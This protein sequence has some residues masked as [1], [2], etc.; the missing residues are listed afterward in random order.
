MID[1][2]VRD[3]VDDDDADFV[4]GAAPT[5][6]ALL[7]DDVVLDAD[8][9]RISACSCGDSQK[10]SPYEIRIASWPRM[11]TVPVASSITVSGS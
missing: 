7:V 11:T 5:C 4:T 10:R 9:C 1:Q 8:T 2:V 3:V 6:D